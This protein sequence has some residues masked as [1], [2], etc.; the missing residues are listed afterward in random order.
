MLAGWN[1]FVQDKFVQDDIVADF[2][3]T[4]P[5]LPNNHPDIRQ[6]HAVRAQFAK[7]WLAGRPYNRRRDRGSG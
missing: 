2:C 7:E 5:L 6:R 4:E 3:R 1:K